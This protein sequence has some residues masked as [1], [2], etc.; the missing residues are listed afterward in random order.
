[1]L[2]LLSFMIKFSLKNILNQIT[3]V[4]RN[5]WMRFMWKHMSICLENKNLCIFHQ[6]SFYDHNWM[7]FQ[8]SSKRCGYSEFSIILGRITKQYIKFLYIQVYRIFVTTFN[9]DNASR[10]LQK[11]CF[12]KLQAKNLYLQFVM[13]NRTFSMW[14][15]SMFI[16][17]LQRNISL[18]L[19]S[20]WFGKIQKLLEVY[21]F[22]NSAG[23]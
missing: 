10:L 14:E 21:K 3:I 22:W 11:L 15:L 8:A 13:S 9:T 18:V 5:V 2:M 12:P 20:G 23:V 19:K 1:M 7:C 16:N 6:F 4:T 17:L